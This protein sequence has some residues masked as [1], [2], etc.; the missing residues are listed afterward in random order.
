MSPR[1]VSNLVV[2][3]GVAMSAPLAL[4]GQ[5]RTPAPEPVNSWSDRFTLG[6]GFGGLS[7]AANLNS[8]GTADWRLGWIGPI[9]GTRGAT[10]HIG[11]PAHGSRGQAPDTGAPPARRG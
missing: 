3:L 2:A 5:A 1:F 7:G 6:G 4:R 11:D 10:R 8:A 9:D